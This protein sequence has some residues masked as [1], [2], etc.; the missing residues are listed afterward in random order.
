MVADAM[1]KLTLVYQ[2]LGATDKAKATAEKLLHVYG[3]NRGLADKAR[4][5]LAAI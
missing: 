1:W 4:K 5:F 3:D 2:Q